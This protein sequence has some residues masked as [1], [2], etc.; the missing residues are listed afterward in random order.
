[1]M[2]TRVEYMTFDYICWGDFLFTHVVTP[3]HKTP[4][5]RICVFTDAFPLV[6]K[7]TKHGITGGFV[8]PLTLNFNEQDQ[9]RKNCLRCKKRQRNERDYFSFCSNFSFFLG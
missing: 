9:N 1:M 4:L 2:E 3:P 5:V 8:L 6:N 7:D